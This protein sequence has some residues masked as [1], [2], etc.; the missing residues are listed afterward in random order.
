VH[1][2]LRFTASDLAGNSASDSFGLFWTNNS[3]NIISY[4]PATSATDVAIA[5]GTA[6]V[7]FDSSVTSI[8][9]ASKIDIVKNS[10][11]VS[12]KA[13]TS[14]VGGV[15]QITYNA[16]ENSTTYRINIAKDAV[17]DADGYMNNASSSTFTTITAPLSP[18]PVLTTITAIP[19]QYTTTISFT[20]DQAGLAKALYGKTSAYG[21]ATDYLAILA[22]PGNEIILDGLDCATT[23][24]YKVY[25]KNNV[26]VENNTS[27]ITFTTTACPTGP[28]A[29]VISAIDATPSQ[30]TAVVNFTSDQAGTA[31]V[32]YGKTIAYGH[33]TDYV[34]MIV[35]S[36]TV[37]LADLDCATTYHYKVY[38]KNSSE[39]EVGSGDNV[40][41]T[42]ACLDTTAPVINSVSL[43]KSAYRITQ[44]ASVTA[45]VVEDDTAVSVT[46]NGVLATESPAGTW[47]ATFAHGK[48][49]IGEYSFNVVAIDSL[50]NTNT[51][52]ITYIVVADD[53]DPAPIVT[54]TAPAVSSTV[55][56]SVSVT[57]TNGTEYQIDGGIWTAIGTEWNTTLVVNGSHTIRAKGGTPT[58]YSDIITVV[59]DN[60]V[61]DITAPSFVAQIPTAGATGVSINPEI[62]VTFDEPLDS[63]T[64]SSDSVKLCLVS[65]ET[66][67]TP[68]AIGSPMLTEGGTRISL[69][70]ASVTLSYNTAYWIKVAATVT[71]LAGNPIIAYDS[72][73]DSSFT[74]TTA[75]VG[76]LAIG[77]AVMIK[78]DGLADDSY[79]N[80]WEWKLRITLPTN[81]NAMALKFANWISGVNTLLAGGNMRY[82][83]EQIDDGIGSVDTPVEITA[84]NTYPDNIVI[85]ND[86]DASVAGIQTDIHIQVKIPATTVGGSYSSAFAVRSEPEIK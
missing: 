66:C 11:G 57:A 16:L 32:I 84:A 28:I 69:G 50:G 49:L 34:A 53:S 8:I 18:A 73:E 51:L 42:T 52:L 26:G 40:F 24:H 74:T 25:A 63:N 86:A 48:S 68:I 9:D 1:Y 10:T 60:T 41:T 55:S 31:K 54:I 56:G 81:E 72:T 65:D 36:N 71:D 79:E 20:S 76:E 14:L 45:T 59:V 62:Y 67:T 13:S 19:G 12:V 83:S 64:I 75:P 5:A 15:L 46:I 78:S 70:G 38:G 77:T 58:G 22:A 35:S 30:H 17:E 37:N 7:I 85:I 61:V 21:F 2:V 80:G 6:T 33:T 4:S 47:T 27:D 44:D 39:L 43:D 29:P 82:Y 23:Y 3:L